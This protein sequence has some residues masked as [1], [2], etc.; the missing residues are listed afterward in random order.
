[1][2]DWRDRPYTGD[3][4][5]WQGGLQP[6]RFSE[7]HTAEEIMRTLCN[8]FQSPSSRRWRS[9][10]SG[11]LFRCR[12]PRHRRPPRTSWC[13]ATSRSIPGA[14]DQPIPDAVLVVK[15]G[16]IE[17]VGARMPS[18]RAPEGAERST[19]TARSSSPASSIRIRTSASSPAAACAA[20]SDGNEIERPGPAR[21][22]GPRRHQPRRPRHPHG[23]GRRRHHRQHHAR[24]RQRHR[25]ADA[26]RQAPRPHRRGDAHHR[27][28]RRHRSSA[29]SRWPTARTPRATARTSSRPRSRA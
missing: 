14:S 19:S 24:L 10:W 23:P 16:K 27:P 17:A 9:C 25:R 1:M 22:P 8:S 7:S 26:L 20:N 6:G 11:C 5:P 13:S 29:A 2:A 12:C 15:D 21:P 18:A 28:V 4:I 3:H